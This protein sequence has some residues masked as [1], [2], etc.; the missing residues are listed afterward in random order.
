MRLAFMANEA[1]SQV[2]RM[3]WRTSYENEIDR[4]C[5]SGRNRCVRAAAFRR[6]RRLRICACAGRG[7]CRAARAVDGGGSAHAGPGIHIR[8]WLLVSGG[9]ALCLA[10]RLLGPAAVCECLLGAPTL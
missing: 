2:R 10:R 6:W 9:C 8:E 1:V 7:L 4:A 3:K 5:F